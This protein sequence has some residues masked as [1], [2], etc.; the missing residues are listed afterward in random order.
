MI[1]GYE[2]ERKF[3]VEF[4]DVSKLNVKKKLKIYQTY[5]K[6][7]ENETQRR[8]RKIES[9][10]K[11]T[12]TYTEKLFLT[13]ITRKEMEYDIDE[14]EYQRLV[15]QAREDCAVIEKIRYCFEYNNQ[16]FELDTYPFSGSLAI[17][18]LELDTPEQ[19]IDF[20]AYL[21]IIKEVTGDSSYANS[22]IAT[23]G[24]FPKN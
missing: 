23:A 9:E 19:L 17:L 8:V 10:G 7:N 22:A 14:V 3:L 5:L 24:S 20:P 6:N 1:K 4:P 18:E 21:N 15:V 12:Y 11:I 16:L 2:I 13:S